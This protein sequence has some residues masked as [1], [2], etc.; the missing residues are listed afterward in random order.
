MGGELRCGGD[1]QEIPQE[2][3]GVST[4]T[5][6]FSNMG[7]TKNSLNVYVIHVTF[8]SRW[9]KSEWNTTLFFKSKVIAQVVG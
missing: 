9:N 4:I 6:I 5:V 1:V 3:T 8:W 2:S 7:L